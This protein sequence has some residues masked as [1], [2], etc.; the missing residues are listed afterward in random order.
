MTL[1]Q[2]SGHKEGLQRARP[3]V[4]SFESIAVYTCVFLSRFNNGG[5]LRCFSSMVPSGASCRRMR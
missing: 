2:D 1:L 4:L 5:D 3:Y